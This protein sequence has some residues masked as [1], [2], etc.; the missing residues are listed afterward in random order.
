MISI[1]LM[2]KETWYLFDQRNYTYSIEKTAIWFEVII[3]HPWFIGRAMLLWSSIFLA[4]HCILNPMATIDIRLIYTH[5]FLHG[6]GAYASSTHAKTVSV[7]TQPLQTPGAWSLPTCLA[8][9]SEP[10]F[11]LHGHSSTMVKRLSFL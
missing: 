10:A 1:D 2:L 8:W 11:H 7:N 5:R 3:A 9:R 4:Y 6:F